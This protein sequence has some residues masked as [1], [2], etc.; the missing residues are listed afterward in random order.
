MMGKFFEALTNYHGK[1]EPLWETTAVLCYEAGRLME[2]AMY[3]KWYGEDSKARLGYYKSELMDVIA[4][5]VLLCESLDLDFEEWKGLGEE[6][7][8]ERFM[9]KEYKR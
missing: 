9:H 2:H 3:L 1:P 5:C 4:Q 8:M 6:K 7:A